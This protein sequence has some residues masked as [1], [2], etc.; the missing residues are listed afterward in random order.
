MNNNTLYKTFNDSQTGVNYLLVES[1]LRASLWNVDEF[2]SND[3]QEEVENWLNKT[4]GVDSVG[5]QPLDYL[6]E[7]YEENYD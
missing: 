3:L 4:N 5:E 2:S 7:H 6:E 1:G